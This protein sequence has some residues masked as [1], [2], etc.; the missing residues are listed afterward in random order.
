MSRLF[1]GI[2]LLT[3]TA[4]M[5]QTLVSALQKLGRQSGPNPCEI[6]HWRIR[7]DNEA[8]IL[9]AEFST[10]DVSLPRMATRLEQLYNLSPG[11]VTYTTAST[12]YGP[13]VTFKT[14]TTNRF[15]MVCFGGLDASYGES[16]AAVL[17]YLAANKT[18][19]ET[20]V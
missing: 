15:R 7:L 9:E 8:V 19:W 13:V 20:E 14:G 18:A 2:E 12:V 16:H 11:A 5:K 10:D 3:M 4:A 6:M 17:A 1:V